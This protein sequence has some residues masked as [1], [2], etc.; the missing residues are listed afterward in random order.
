M[1]RSHLGAGVGGQGSEMLLPRSSAAQNLK[2]KLKLA[3]NK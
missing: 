1:H 3:R 2:L